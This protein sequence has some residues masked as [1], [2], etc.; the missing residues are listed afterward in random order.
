[1]HDDGF[2]TNKNS[3]APSKAGTRKPSEEDECDIHTSSDDAIRQKDSSLSQ[4]KGDKNTQRLKM[5]Y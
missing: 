4:G 5:E 2:L 1:V 3:A